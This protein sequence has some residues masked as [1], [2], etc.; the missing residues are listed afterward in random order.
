MYKLCGRKYETFQTVTS[1]PDGWALNGKLCDSPPVKGEFIGYVTMDEGSVISCWK[2]TSKLPIIL[3]V[4][5]AL[6]LLSA[7]TAFVLLSQKKD[8]AVGGTVLRQSMDDT[9]IVYN[10]LMTYSNG[11]VD[12][13]FQNGDYQ[14]TV[15][16]SGDGIETTQ[17]TLE[18]GTSMATM[19]V[20]INT[21]K[22]VIEAVLK[23][24]TETSLASYPVLIEVEANMN[25]TAGVASYFEKEGIVYE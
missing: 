12:L 11:S 7:V 1:P 9:I 18:P 23:F 3:A 24:E 21:E 13:L 19:P 15:T 20:Q 14:T 4:V 10:G 17:A 16:L 2:Y 5:L 8:I 6:A 25:G 22:D